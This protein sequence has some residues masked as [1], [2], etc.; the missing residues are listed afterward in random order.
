MLTS[1]VGDNW[2]KFK[3]KT[4]GFFIKTKPKNKSVEN[5]KQIKKKN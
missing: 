4:K 5:E 1:I 2:H 3:T